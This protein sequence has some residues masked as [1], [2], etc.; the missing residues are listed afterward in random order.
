M[1]I[2][3]MAVSLVILCGLLQLIGC[4]G[5]RGIVG[6]WQQTNGTETMEFLKDGTFVVENGGRPMGGGKYFVVDD[7]RIKI[8]PGGLQSLAG[9]ML[10][11]YV[12]SGKDLTLT[13]PDGGGDTKYHLAELP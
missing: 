3:N 2:K 7:N 9:P 10:T 5:Q 1:R 8:E 13:A 12:I 11:K 4:S 6:K